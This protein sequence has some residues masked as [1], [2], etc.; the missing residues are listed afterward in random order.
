[1]KITIY[2]K[3]CRY[4]SVSNFRLFIFKI[5]SWDTMHRSLVSLTRS[6]FDYINIL[7]HSKNSIAFLLRQHCKAHKISLLI[8]HSYQKLSNIFFYWRK[9]E[10]YE[11]FF[12]LFVFSKSVWA[13]ARARAIGWSSCQHCPW[14]K[15][16]NSMRTK[17]FQW[18]LSQRIWSFTFLL[19]NRFEVQLTF[20]RKNGLI[21]FK[22]MLFL[23]LKN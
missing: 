23:C 3:C 9:F 7:I 20:L 14:W 13:R 17:V 19:S 16:P 8:L 2:W 21:H 4:S 1:M 5:I 11:R 15:L 18:F 6:H 10:Q 22:L 12:H